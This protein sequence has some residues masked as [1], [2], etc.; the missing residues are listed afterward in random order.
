MECPGSV[1]L[2][3]EMAPADDYVE[4]PEYR[5]HGTSAH[6]VATECLHNGCD[7]WE[8][9]EQAFEGH[10]ASELDL[11]HIQSYVDYCRSITK[12]GDEFWIEHAIGQLVD[13]RPHPSFYGTVDYAT[14]SPFLLHV[15]DFKYGAG[16]S[17]SPINNP[18]CMYYAYGLILDIQRTAD[19][20]LDPQFP[21]RITIVQ[22]RV[23]G[24]KTERVWDTTVEDIL[25]WGREVLLPKMREAD[26]L[27]NFKAGDHCRFCPA[28]LACPLL[29]GMFAVAA[30]ID[31]KWIKGADGASLGQEYALISAAKKYIKAVEEETYARLMTGWNGDGIVKLVQ[32]KAN[33]VWKDGA[34]DIMQMTFGDLAMTEP[35]LKSPA[36]LEALGEQAKE[37]V[38]E[39]AYSPNTGL[40]V[41]LSADKRVGVKVETPANTFAHIIAGIEGEN[42]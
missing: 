35:Q 42:P 40:T 26:I 32:Q 25:K 36:Q 1:T 29:K 22:P 14:L 9:S 16:V 37:V 8:L 24:E 10:M 41:A 33:R 2:A 4:A 3:K 21:V 39:W 19:H 6:A 15:I 28:K 30:T 12:E 20:R 38:K 5:T 7:T 18:Q 23:P 13:Q 34:I 11:D 31:T 17:I 27:D